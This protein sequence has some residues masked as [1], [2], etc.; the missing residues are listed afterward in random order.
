[1]STLEGTHHTGIFLFG[2][3]HFKNNA[4][5]KGLF[6]LFWNLSYWDI[7]DKNQNRKYNHLWKIE[8]RKGGWLYPKKKHIA[9]MLNTMMIILTRCWRGISLRN[10]N[11]TSENSGP[12]GSVRRGKCRIVGSLIFWKAARNPSES[13]STLSS[14]RTIILCVPF[15]GPSPKGQC[16]EEKA[17]Q[18]SKKEAP[19]RV[20]RII[21]QETGNL[22]ENMLI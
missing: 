17:S 22:S 11:V 21:Y 5:Y 3:K 18:C 4:L 13:N 1:M 8:R 20:P 16:Q 7:L 2:V 9:T 6:S 10:M 19:Q 14:R 12:A 15:P